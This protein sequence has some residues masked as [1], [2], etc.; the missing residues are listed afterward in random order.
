MPS[1]RSA[2]F[3]TRSSAPST[4]TLLYESIRTRL[5]F[6]IC[7]I[8]ILERVSVFPVPGGPQ[9]NVIFSVVALLKA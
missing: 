7:S 9:I 5:P 4:E 1:G 6:K 8:A 3:A 2:F